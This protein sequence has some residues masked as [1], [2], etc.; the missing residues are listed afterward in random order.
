MA[1]A[2]PSRRPGSA[3]D[4]VIRE[5]DRSRSSSEMPPPSSDTVSHTASGPADR[6]HLDGSRPVA[7]RVRGEVAHDLTNAGSADRG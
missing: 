6:R 3:G 2:E 1:E 7:E 5:E 4:P